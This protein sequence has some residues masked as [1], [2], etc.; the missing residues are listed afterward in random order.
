[1]RAVL[2]FRIPMEP[3]NT[4]VRNGTAGEQVQKVFGAIKPEAVYFNAKDGTRGGVAI[5]DVPE[6]SKIPSLAE[7]LF[8]AF[9]ATVE[10][11]PCMTPEDFA[12]SEVDALGKMF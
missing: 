12:K 2:Y 3:F 6:A 9:N 1:M 5:V 7:P 11:H 4:M 8:L 10:I